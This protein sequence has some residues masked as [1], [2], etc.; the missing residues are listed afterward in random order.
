MDGLRS[1]PQLYDPDASALLVR[2][3]RVSGG[4]AATCVVSDALGPAELRS[5]TAW[6]AAA[7]A[8]ALLRRL[9]TLCDELG[10]C[11]SV[12]PSRP[13][14]AGPA[15]PRLRRSADRLAARLGAP[16]DGTPLCVLAAD[17]D[18]LGAA[19]VSLLAEDADRARPA[20]PPP[21]APGP[22][23]APRHD[24]FPGR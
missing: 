7:A 8:A 20:G 13:V 2:A 23:A 14:V 21:S 16:G 11:W 5:G 24:G 9:P 18:D 4:G 10:E 17:V 15:R 12:P 3:H 6:R 19:A 22:G 1:R